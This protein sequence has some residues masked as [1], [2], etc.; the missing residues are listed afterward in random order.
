VVQATGTQRC[1][2]RI[3]IRRQFTFRNRRIRL[4]HNRINNILRRS[5]RTSRILRPLRRTNRT[6]LRWKRI[7]RILRRPNHTHR[8]QHPRLRLHGTTWKSSL[9]GVESRVRLF[10]GS[11]K[12]IAH[13]GDGGH[14]NW[15]RDTAG[16]T[17]LPALVFFQ[18][19][20]ADFVDN[21]PNAAVSDVGEHYDGK[22][23]IGVTS[24]R[25]TIAKPGTAVS[26]AMGFDE[27]AEAIRD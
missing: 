4:R 26:C 17:P 23:F 8:I 25:G 11:N 7:N 20:L 27:P 21:A 2:N 14:Y 16:L 18:I 15:I 13:L 6:R 3:R 19:D 22:L 12:L 1:N 10:D 24:Y 9:P 5:S